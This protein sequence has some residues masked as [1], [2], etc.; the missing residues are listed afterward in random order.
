MTFV[1]LLCWSG[2]LI[3]NMNKVSCM[4]LFCS[5]TLIRRLISAAAT[6]SS[7]LW[8]LLVDEIS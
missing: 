1:G 8:E 4:K 6:S 5:N 2:L 3:Q 7:D